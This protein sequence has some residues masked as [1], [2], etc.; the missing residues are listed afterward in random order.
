MPGRYQPPALARAQCPVRV[1]TICARVV[2]HTGAVAIPDSAPQP[3]CPFCG[4][5]LLPGQELSSD[6]V[7][8]KAL[9]GRV[10]VPAHRSCNSRFGAGAEGS[11]RNR[12]RW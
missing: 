7:F 9:G 11:C 10:Q 8:A 3:R 2:T 4:Q 6:H 12:A 1:T 5:A